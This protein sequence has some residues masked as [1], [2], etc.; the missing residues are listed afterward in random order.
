[1]AKSNS[2]VGIRID[3]RKKRIIV[4][5]AYERYLAMAACMSDVTRLS[6]VYL[7]G[8]QGKKS[9]GEI[10]VFFDLKPAT[11]THHLRILTNLGILSKQKIGR[12]VFYQ[13]EPEVLF[14]AYKEIA[15]VMRETRSM[16]QPEKQGQHGTPDGHI[17]ER[18]GKR[19]T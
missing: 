11:M 8:T 1:M 6:T 13:F 10:A 14:K 3:Q 12:Q 16:P 15:A 9:F 7:L 2:S 17:A 4:P 19:K 18:K 5:K